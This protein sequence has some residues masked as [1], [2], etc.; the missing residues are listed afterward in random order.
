[1]FSP[2]ILESFGWISW[3]QLIKSGIGR[4]KG[5]NLFVIFVII[6]V[7]IIFVIIH[8]FLCLSAKYAKEYSKTFKYVIDNAIEYFLASIARL[9]IWNLLLT[10]FSNTAD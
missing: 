4:F 2:R 6:L 8:A 5:I 1:M 3:S 7:I 9:S 10:L